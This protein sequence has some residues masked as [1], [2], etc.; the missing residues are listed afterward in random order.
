MQEHL[1]VAL[2]HAGE[3]VGHHAKHM[4][5][6][7]E[8]QHALAAQAL[9]GH[10]AAFLLL[11]KGDGL[12]ADGA[13]I[14]YINAGG[15]GSARSAQC[16][17][18]G[19]L[20]LEALAEH[21]LGEFFGRALGVLHQRFPAAAHD[22]R[23]G[24]GLGHQM[25]HGGVLQRGIQQQRLAA[26]HQQRPE[27]HRPIH[28]GFQAKPHPAV[29]TAQSR[30]LDTGGGLGD[31][32]VE[33]LI[34]HLLLPILFQPDLGHGVTL[35]AEHCIEIFEAKVLFQQFA[36]LITGQRHGHTSIIC[37]TTRSRG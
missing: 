21:A 13:A 32:E 36:F 22:Q 17:A 12:Q 2:Q 7:Q 20:G 19:P 18:V 27:Q 29:G 6:R 35:L 3:Q 10:A 15:I 30:I 37:N 34:G 8:A 25:A 31:P 9:V 16:H 33:I 1:R 28:A 26:R 11:H 4:V 24:A 14:V 5:Q 23:R